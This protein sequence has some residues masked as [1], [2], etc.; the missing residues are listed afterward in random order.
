MA[1]DDKKD[2]DNI[3]VDKIWILVF[4][5]TFSTNSS[6]NKPWT[7]D[8]TSLNTDDPSATNYAI[9][10]RLETFR[11][12]TDNKFEFKLFWPNSTGKKYQH[13]KQTSNPAK[14]SSKKNV[15]GYEEIKIHNTAHHWGGLEWNGDQCL[16][17][18]SAKHESNWFYA[19]GTYNQWNGAMPGPDI[20]VD[21]VKM[22][23][24]HF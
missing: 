7:K 5:Q 10:D 24:L 13:W 18:G 6:D 14:T 4:R 11:D 22:Y 3:Q 15:T 23:N 20:A 9:L 21:K 2:T 16:I 1:D 17:S 12:P 19:L 8:V